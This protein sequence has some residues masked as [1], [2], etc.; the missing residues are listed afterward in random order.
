MFMQ[1]CLVLYCKCGNDKNKN[2]VDIHHEF[3]YPTSFL[4]CKQSTLPLSEMPRK[5]KLLW[6]VKDKTIECKRIIGRLEKAF[7]LTDYLAYIYASST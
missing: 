5:K 6:L 7:D 2:K 3:K 1:Y 4:R